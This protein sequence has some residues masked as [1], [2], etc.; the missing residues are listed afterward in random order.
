MLQSE[1]NISMTYKISDVSRLS[2]AEEM[3]VDLEIVIPNGGIYSN[4]VLNLEQLVSNDVRKCIN[5]GEA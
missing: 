4:L 3:A 5:Q 1:E 2:T